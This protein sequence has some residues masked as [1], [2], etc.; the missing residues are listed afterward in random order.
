[1]AG[2]VQGVRSNTSYDPTSAC[3]ACHLCTSMESALQPIDSRLH[4]IAVTQC[5]GT[6]ALENCQIP[7]S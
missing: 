3:S 1:M 7:S 2:L 5:S 6:A 4:S